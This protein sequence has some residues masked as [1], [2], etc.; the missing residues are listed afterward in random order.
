VDNLRF[1]NHLITEGMVLLVSNKQPTYIQ[2]RLNSFLSPKIYD[3]MAPV[4]YKPLM[5]QLKAVKA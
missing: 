4:P 3:P 1:R 2:D 5:P